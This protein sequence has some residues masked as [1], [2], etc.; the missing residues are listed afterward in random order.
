MDYFCVVAL[1]ILI[2][3]VVGVVNEVPR[4]VHGVNLAFDHAK[5]PLYKV[6]CVRGSEFARELFQ[7]EICSPETGVWRVSGEPFTASASFDYGVYWNGSIHWISNLHK[8]LLYFNIDE[9]RFGNMPLPATLDGYG[10]RS[11]SYLGESC[12]HLHIIGSYDTQIAFNVYEMKRDYSEWFVKY[13]VDLTIAFPEM[14]YISA[15]INR[16]CYALSVHSWFCRFLRKV[17]RFNLDCNTFEEISDFED[18]VVE[19]SLP[20]AFEYIASL[21]CV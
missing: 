4:I 15:L 13:R 11:I 7:V 19:S 20:R 10:R 5:S 17:I 12:D 14:A 6:V 21:A 1:G 8:E 16:I 18:S 3:G 9:E 2:V